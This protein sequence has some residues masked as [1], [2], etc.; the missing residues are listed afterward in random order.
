M[1]EPPE[2]CE[3]HRLINCEYCA[4]STAD[5][6]EIVFITEGW[7]NAYHKTKT[8]TSLKSGQNHVTKRGGTPAQVIAVPIKTAKLYRDKGPCQTCFPWKKQ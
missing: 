2:P 5:S 6:Q 3:N 7:G 4:E 8:C 1:P